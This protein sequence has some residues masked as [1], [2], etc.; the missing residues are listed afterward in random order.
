MKAQNRRGDVREDSG[1]FFEQHKVPIWVAVVVVALLIGS[2]AL[3][4]I[5]GSSSKKEKKVEE[6]ETQ[7]AAPITTVTP[8]VEHNETLEHTVQA[9]EYIISIATQYGVPWESVVLAN[10]NKLLANTQTYCASKS[11]SYTHNRGRRGH[12]CNFL[13]FDKNGKPL[14]HANTLMPG[15]VLKIPSNTAPEQ[16]QE[17]VNAISGERVVVVIDETGSMAG[18]DGV[19]DRSRVSAWYLQA[20][21]NADKKIVKV[22]MF[23]EG[24]LRELDA[25]AMEFHARGGYENTRHALEHATNKYKPDAIVLV[26]DE[27]GDDWANWQSLHLPPVIAHSLSRV[28][29]QMMRE[30]ASFTHGQFLRSYEGPLA[31]IKAPPSR[32]ALPVPQ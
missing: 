25:S 11:D 4:G 7:V 17:T 13:A 28:S 9:G 15:D 10:E 1:T 23:A 30:L 16:I 18:D 32:I 12:F 8:S 24:S 2:A 29:D 31:S 20:I 27:P 6:A 14:V 19:D 26:T 22:I 3:W 5:F 21:K